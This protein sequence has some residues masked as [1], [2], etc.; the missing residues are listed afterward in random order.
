MSTESKIKE[1]AKKLVKERN[2]DGYN[3]LNKLVIKNGYV[4]LMH[5]SCEGGDASV[6]VA[7][8]VPE[9]W[10]DIM[11]SIKENEADLQAN[12]VSAKELIENIL[13]KYEIVSFSM[14]YG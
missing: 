11:N 9:L 7:K 6:L 10:Q 13:G 8:D 3:N 2:S 5:M 1:L 12:Y 14:G 4:G